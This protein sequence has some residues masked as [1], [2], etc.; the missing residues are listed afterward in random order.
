M[1]V[2]LSNRCIYSQLYNFIL[3][4]C[5]FKVKNINKK[6]KSYQK[7]WMLNLQVCLVI[8]GSMPSRGHVGFMLTHKIK[9]MHE[10]ACKLHLSLSPECV[11]GQVSAKTLSYIHFP[12]ST[13]KYATLCTH[14]LIIIFIII[15]TCLDTPVQCAQLQ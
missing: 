1:Q 11:L 13:H 14:K 10:F 9:L 4:S 3:L 2:L 5:Q 7:N 8:R 12:P 15:A 6:K